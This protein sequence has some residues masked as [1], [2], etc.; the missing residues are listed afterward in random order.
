LYFYIDN[1][2]TEDD[3]VNIEADVEAFFSIITDAEGFIYNEITQGNLLS[4]TNLDSIAGIESL[5]DSWVEIGI[6]PEFEY[7]VM[8]SFYSAHKDQT[9]KFERKLREMGYEMERST[10]RILL[11]FKGHI[12]RGEKINRWTVESLE[13]EY[14]KI[15]LLANK[16]SNIVE[17]IYAR[18]NEVAN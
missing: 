18:K 17:G 9:D 16:H 11:I 4:S 12:L 14:S 10:K 5:V 6:N 1:K 3:F 7:P 13:S 15:L 8:F 2:A